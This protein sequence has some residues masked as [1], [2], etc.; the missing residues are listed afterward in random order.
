[1]STN[2]YTINEQ[3]K[4]PWGHWQVLDAGNGFVVKK[5]TVQAGQKLSLQLHQH[6]QEHWTV[7]S[8]EALVTIG[9]QQLVK[10]KGEFAFIQARTLHRVLNSGKELLVF[11]EVQIGDLLDEN[12][13][14]R[15]EDD[16]GRT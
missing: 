4:R 2:H 9:E 3:G 15:F 8:G 13:I 11:I 10:K 7:V 14:E 6:R 12:D 1:M 5:I 16:Y